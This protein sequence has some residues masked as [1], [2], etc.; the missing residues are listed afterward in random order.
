MKQ[1]Q[2]SPRMSE[3]KKIYKLKEGDKYLSYHILK[4]ILQETSVPIKV[5]EEKN[6]ELFY[7]T[8]TG[9]GKVIFS[10]SMK[11]YGPVKNG[12]LETG[13]PEPQKEDE[14]KNVCIILF[15]DGTKYEGEIHSNRITGKGK[16]YF[17]SGAK[18]T[19]SVLNGLRDGF[20]KYFSPEGV[21]YEGE[22]KDGLKH[23]KGMMKT[24]SM[25]YDGS[26]ELGNIN[27]KGKIKWENGNIFEG[28]FKENKM[29]GYGYMIW[30]DLLEKY[31]GKWKDDKQNGNGMHIWYEPQGE[32]KEMR[33]RYVGQWKNGAR[34]GYGVFFYSNGA[35][36]EGEWKNN[37]KNGFGIIKLIYN[38]Y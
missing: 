6:S 17:P 2:Q 22:W 29:N 37:L 32:L 31:I 28:E 21:T 7:E 5:I 18:Y 35:R 25:T 4:A 30:Y 24:E 3:D 36:Y 10:N 38:I 19:G 23:G 33:N 20:G 14:K 26:W 9:K 13:N 16:Y 8:L 11:Y 1:Q 34:N 15:P 27:G 12:L